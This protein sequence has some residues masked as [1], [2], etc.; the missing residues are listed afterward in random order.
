VSRP[1]INGAFEFFAGWLDQSFWP[2]GIY[3]APTEDALL[4]DLTAIQTFGL[5][6]VRLHQKVNPQ[7]WYYHADRLGIIVLQDMIQKY[8]GA[9][10]ATIQP[11]NND[12]KA[13]VSNLY[14]HPSIVQW[15]V[16]N[17]G[18][19]VGVFNVPQTVQFAESLDST[20]LFDTNSG[21]PAN[22]LH[23]ADVNDI[24]T[25]PYPGDPIPSLTQ[26]G[27]VGEFGGI[28]AFVAGHEWV[29]GQCQTYLAVKTPQDEAD[30]YVGMA[31]TILSRKDD[32]SCS[33]YTQ[34]SDVERECDGFLNYDRTNKFNDA[35][36]KSIYDAN[37]ALIKG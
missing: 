12:F 24:H 18:D 20:R 1:F 16:F 27:M 25:Y 4:S 9:S 26:Y 28:G 17:E 37:Q 30:T 5:N 29:P 13:M 2:D 3:T 33:I 8:G 35:Q 22:D 11:F 34:I 15:T 36:T 32:I 21:G 14:N 6:A 10:S 31:K 7:R 19:C 23:I